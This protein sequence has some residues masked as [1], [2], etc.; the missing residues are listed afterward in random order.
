MKVLWVDDDQALVSASIPV[1]ER[2]GFQVAVANTVSQA[3]AFLRTM[4]SDLEGVLL[5]V[6]LKAGESGL[7]LMR[8]INA[9]YPH[10]KL[11]ILT[12]FPSYGEN[13]EAI[14]GGANLYFAK[15]RKALPLDP[16]QQKLFFDSLRRAFAMSRRVQEPLKTP[17]T[18]RRHSLWLSGLF[19]L[20]LFVV[21]ISGVL[22]VSRSV[23]PWV[24][25]VVL[26]AGI[27]FYSVVGAFILRAQGD[28]VLKERTFLDLVKAALRYVPYI[29]TSADSG[30]KKS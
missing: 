1:F 11:V 4:P 9:R 19:F 16:I 24:L 30:K 8:E 14:E 5:D 17:D 26:V 25:P 29:K 22:I 15:F 21:V 18:P 6:R 3:L 20:L 7:E 10:L 12:G 2:H 13:V 27:I 23:S 28:E